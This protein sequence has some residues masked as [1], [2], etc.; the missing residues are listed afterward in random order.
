MSDP[1]EKQYHRFNT[2]LSVVIAALVATVGGLWLYQ[3]KDFKFTSPAKWMTDQAL[4]NSDTGFPKFEAVKGMDLKGMNFDPKTINWQGTLNTDQ[5]RD[6]ERKFG[7]GSGSSVRAPSFQPP[8]MP[9]Y[10]PPSG[11]RR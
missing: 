1:L 10:T 7:S 2:I 8:S 4:K 3:N 9:R 5:M 11:P 6:I